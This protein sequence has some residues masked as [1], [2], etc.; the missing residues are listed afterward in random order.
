MQC[1]DY[2]ERY[3]IQ[4]ILPN[5][6][7]EAVVLLAP[8]LKPDP[9]FE[10]RLSDGAVVFWGLNEKGDEAAVV[11]VPKPPKEDGSILVILLTFLNMNAQCYQLLQS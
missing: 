4:N 7:V 8:K 3:L 9:V 2:V 10:V 11:V 1:H 6:P 5:R